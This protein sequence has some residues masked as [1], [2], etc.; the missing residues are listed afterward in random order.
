MINMNLHQ[1]AT[2]TGATLIGKATQFRGISTDSREDCKGKLFVALSGPNFR[3]EDY[4]PQALKKGAVAVLVSHAQDNVASQLVCENTLECLSTIA[5]YWAKQCKTKIIAITGSNGKTTVKNMIHSILSLQHQCVA[6]E[7][8]FNNEIGVPLTLCKLSSADE[9]AVIEMG[10]AKLGDIEWLV[11]LVDIHTG[12]LTSTSAAHIGRF[13]SL[14][15]IVTEKGKIIS[16]LNSNGYAILPKDNENFEKWSQ[17]TQGNVVSFGSE[18]ES[19]VRMVHENNVFSIDIGKSV[20]EDIHLPIPG[21]HNELNAAA[22][23]AA[24]LTFGISAEIIKE[25]LEKFVPAKGRLELVG[26]IKG[27]K[28]INDCYNANLQSVK[29][30]IDVL[31]QYDGNTTLVFG[32]MA[33]L[34]EDSMEMHRQVGSYAKQHHVTQLLTVGNDSKFASDEFSEQPLHFAS[35]AELEKFLMS[36]WQSVGTVLVKGSRSMRLETVID[37]LK[38]M[39][40]VA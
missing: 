33:E 26:E 37:N 22:A 20:I 29:A 16:T 38:S 7:G 30:A 23:T 24:V 10:A 19:D 12:V 8:N 2:L 1:V 40:D 39:E 9:F 28:V 17:S 14:E 25:G 31:S 35:K 6:T 21:K 32:D 3:G 27:N 18:K 36:H 5:K 15:N 34:G 4:C 11:S 13:G